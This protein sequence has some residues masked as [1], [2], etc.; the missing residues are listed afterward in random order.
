MSRLISFDDK[1]TNNVSLREKKKYEIASRA[2]KVFPR[3]SKDSSGSLN[4]GPVVN[5]FASP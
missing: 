3:F 2:E 5:M 1:T 4:V